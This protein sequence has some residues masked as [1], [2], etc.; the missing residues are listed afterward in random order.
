VQTAAAGQLGRMLLAM[1]KDSAYPLVNVVHRDAQVEL[2]QSLGAEHVLN[3]SRDGFDAELKAVC[4][5]LGATIAFDAVA[6]DMSGT[7]LN[8]MPR[9]GVVYVYGALSEQP[10]RKI[11]PVET[12]FHDKSLHGFYLGNW[13]RKQGVFGALRA[14]NYLQRSLVSGL[15]ETK[16]Q[17]RLKLDE[18]LDGL[19]R[20]VQNM[21]DGKVLITP[22]AQ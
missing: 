16:V 1:A 22:Q 10:C 20:Y 13:L 2:L 19:P 6:G 4:K 9:G 11:D 5:E 17:Q 12:V 18:V 8:V 15:I 21:T 14:A 7:L 3:S